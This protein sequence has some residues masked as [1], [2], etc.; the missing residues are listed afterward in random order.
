MIVPGGVRHSLDH[1]GVALVAQIHDL[2]AGLACLEHSGQ[3]ICGG[4]R[5]GG[6][7]RQLARGSPQI[8]S[9]QAPAAGVMRHQ[10]GG[11]AQAPL[12]AGCGRRGGR[13]E[14]PHSLLTILAAA[15]YLVTTSGLERP[16]SC[17]ETIGGANVSCRT[18]IA[19]VRAGHHHGGGA[20]QGPR[21]AA[22]IPPARYRCRT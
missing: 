9:I 11:D 2:G 16:S 14:I 1:E 10:G 17:T 4:G 6:E 8:L 20:S 12:A 7:R 19:R 15:L 21:R 22:H 5:G 13:P 18:G 3:G